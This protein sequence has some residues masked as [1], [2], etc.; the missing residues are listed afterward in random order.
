MAKHLY[1][2]L[3]RSGTKLQS[4]LLLIMRLYWGYQFFLTGTGKFQNID[5]VVQYF[6]S[7]NI[8]FA[9]ASAYTVA[10]IETVGGLAL[11]FGLASRLLCIPLICTL[12]GAYLTAH[13]EALLNIFNNPDQFI[14]QAPFN[15]IL[16]SLIVF[17]FGPGKF[18]L[19]NLIE[20]KMVK[21]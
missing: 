17:C 3:I 5:N 12:A 9:V 1:E 13:R 2:M 14:S 18:S 15:F 10:S 19:D 6:D 11:F 21:K 7:L 16:T 4:Y 8:P 20:K